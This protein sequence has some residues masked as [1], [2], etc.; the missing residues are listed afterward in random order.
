LKP[1]DQLVGLKRNPASEKK[2]D[3]PL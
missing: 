3:D 2:E 1:I